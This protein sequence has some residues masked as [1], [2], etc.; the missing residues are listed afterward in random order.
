MKLSVKPSQSFPLV[1][2]KGLWVG[3]SNV[4]VGLNAA[5][6]GKASLKHTFHVLFK[7]IKNACCHTLLLRIIGAILI[8][9]PFGYVSKCLV[10]YPVLAILE[11]L[12]IIEIYITSNGI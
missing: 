10:L 3:L 11:F 4:A 2:R 7:S 9:I 12:T 1:S 5:C 6:I 8:I